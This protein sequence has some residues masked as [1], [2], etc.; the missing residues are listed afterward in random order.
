MQIMPSFR[1]PRIP[2]RLAIFLAPLAAL[3]AF[4]VL[5]APVAGAGDP[6]C[7]GKPATIVSNA[8]TITGGKAPDV[9][10]AGPGNNVIKGEGGNDLICAGAG[11]DTDLRRTR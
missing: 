11:D 7:Q 9:I 4:L 8:A 2:A 5:G 6:T 1:H 10:V 3:T